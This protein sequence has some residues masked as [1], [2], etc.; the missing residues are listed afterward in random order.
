MSIP[1]GV[2]GFSPPQYVLIQCSWVSVAAN[3][4]GQ[5]RSFPLRAFTVKDTSFRKLPVCNFIIKRENSGVLG[6]PV[7]R[8]LILPGTFLRALYTCWRSHGISRGDS[9]AL[10]PSE[11][12]RCRMTLLAD[13]FFPLLLIL[14]M[15]EGFV[16]RYGSLSSLLS[17]P[18]GKR[19]KW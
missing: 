8:L 17:F 15:T 10:T 19:L 14:S 2:L 7:L 6:G 18:W 16:R 9:T 3:V 4:L 5:V 12:C 13:S 11:P 1:I